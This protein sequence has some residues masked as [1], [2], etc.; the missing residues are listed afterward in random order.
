MPGLIWAESKPVPVPTVNSTLFPRLPRFSS[1][2]VVLAFVALHTQAQSSPPADTT[3]VVTGSVVQRAADEAPYAISVVGRESLRSAGPMINLSEALAQVPGLVV[4]N[5]SNYAQDLQISSRGFGARAGFGVRGIRLYTDGIPASGPDGQGQVSAFDLAG[6]QRIEVLRGPNSVLYGNSSGGVIAL[7]SAPVKQPEAE[8]DLD[9]GSFGLKQV[10]ATLGAPLGHGFEMRMSLSSMQVDGFR[11][12]SAAERT[13]GNL[14]L[15]WRGAHDT[16]TLLVNDLDQPAQDALGLT[17]AQFDTDPY[18]T[19]PVAL[20]FNTRKTTHQTQAGANWRHSF[21]DGV[22]RE[23]TLAVYGGRRDVTQWQAI[24]V[25]TQA[26]AK[27]GGGVVDFTRDCSGAEG[28]LRLGWTDVDLV[29]GAAVDSQR[30]ARRGYENYRGTGASQVL[31]VTGKLRRN[32]YDTASSSDLFAQSEWRI[33]PTVSAS[34][35]VRG[36]KVETAAR[37]A[38]IAGANVDDSGSLQYSYTNPVL[39][40]RWQLDRSLQLQVSASRGFESPTLGELAYRPDGAGGLN[41]AL[42]PQTSQQLELGAKWRTGDWQADA[43]LFR[44][45]VSNEISVMTNSGGRSSYQNVGSTLRQGLELSGAWRPAS[46]WRAAAALTWLDAQYQD[47]FLTCGPPPCSAPTV[48]VAAGNR[49]AGT[50]RSNAWAEVAWRDV[51]WGEFGL[52]ARGAARTAVND[53][54]SDFAAGYGLAALRWTKAYTL[55]GGAKFEW[56]LRVDNLFGRHYAGSVIVND[57]NAR[58]FEPGAP[59][60]ALLGM[61]LIGAL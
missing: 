34:A 57:G 19:T 54:N 16:V 21:D 13:A 56:L 6:A 9:L 20:Q 36:G 59:R 18:Q 4:N 48:A 11:P 24:P 10:R 40:L 27:H 1:T 45:D 51:H 3:V 30:D 15:G 17:R 43:T 49:I 58:Y 46:A 23:S 41:T 42:Q 8:A 12:Q 25:A 50:Q 55:P 14:R 32:E 61:R 35:G 38:Y 2:P 60:T 44:A 37:D 5:R 26:N 28:R 52:E 7:F 53:L 31:G 47:S 33:S 22:L 29:L 39:G